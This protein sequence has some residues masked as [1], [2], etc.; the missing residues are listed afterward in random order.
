MVRPHGRANIDPRN[1]R[2]TGICQRCGF[3]VN[4]DEL[5]WQYEFGGLKLINLRI[6]VCRTCYDEPQIQLRTLILP[7]DPVP[8]EFPVP[9]LYNY[10]DNPVSGIGV[11]PSDL[12]GTSQSSAPTFT[13][14]LTFF[15]GVNSA[16]DGN[17]NKQSWR[18]AAIMTSIS[19]Y[20][21]TV[22]VNWNG[23]LTS[24]SS[25]TQQQTTYGVGAFAVYAPS[26][27]PIFGG[28]ATGIELQGSN[29]GATWTVLYNGT[30]AGTAGETFTS[31]SSNFQSMAN[32]PYHQIA[33]Q[34]DGVNA[35]YVSQ[36]QL[37]VLNTGQ[38]EE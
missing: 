6:L 36:I 19:S 25:V 23:G 13:G 35:V 5:R 18:S 34:G 9:E 10:T 21:N 22:G 38:N 17:T 37:S 32:F 33:V 2:A 31:V 27:Q 1:P 20:Q 26:D 3:F 16:F 28:G 8:V 15:A 24:P 14:N 7:P 30:T 12:L 4:H 11:I 29:D